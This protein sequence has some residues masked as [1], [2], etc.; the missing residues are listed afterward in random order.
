MMSR[1]DQKGQSKARS[2]VAAG[3]FSGVSQDLVNDR[4]G[5]EQENA[6]NVAAHEKHQHPAYPDG[7]PVISLYGIV[8]E[9]VTEEVAPVERRNREEVKDQECEIDFHRGDAEKNDGLDRGIHSQKKLVAECGHDR[10]AAVGE[11]MNYDKEDDRSSDSKDEVRGRPG[12]GGE[13]VVAANLREIPGDDGSGF[14]PTD[15]DVSEEAEPEKR[16]EDDDG[17]DEESTDWIDVIN[18]IERHAALK[19]SGLIAQARSHPGMGTL[20]ETERED[21][22]DKLEDRNCKLCRLQMMLPDWKA[23][24]SMIGPERRTASS[25]RLRI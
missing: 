5:R 19:A 2:I 1:F 7:Y 3:P 22:E 23:Q 11:S 9:H 25:Q 13:V 16:A 12:E 10:C 20:M 8:W 24:G 15:E 6:H 21:E 4:K 17:G 14:C 18:G